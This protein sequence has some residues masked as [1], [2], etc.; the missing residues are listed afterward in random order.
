MTIMDRL[1][2]WGKKTRVIAEIIGR[3]DGF[4]F[5]RPVLYTSTYDRKRADYEFWDKLRSG[6]ADGYE[7]GGIYCQPVYD[8]KSSYVI[9]DAPEYLIDDPDVS[10]SM[11]EHTNREIMA[12]VNRYHARFIQMVS[13]LYALGDQFVV[14]NPNGELA[15]PTPES[16]V[17]IKF[18]PY[19]SMR[20][21]YA[22]MRISTTLG[23]IETW[24]YTPETI[25][26]VHGPGTPDTVFDNLVGEVPV[27]PWAHN[28]R[29]NE[30][31][32]RPDME[33][34]LPWLMEHHDVLD[35]TLDGVKLMGNPI[36]TFT[37]VDDLGK[38]TDANKTS[39][40]QT[41]YDDDSVA[42]TR[43]LL[44]F[45]RQGAILAGKGG[46]FKFVHPAIGFTEDSIRIIDK[47]FDV[48]LKHVRVP[49]VVWGGARTGDRAAAEVQ[50]P[51]FVRYIGSLR[52]SLDGSDTHGFKALLRIWLKTM[53]LTD[54]KIAVARLRSQWKSVALEDS[55]I[56]L[57]KVIYSKGENL[58]R[59]ETALRALGIQ[60]VSDPVEEVRAAKEEAEEYRDDYE[61]MLNAAARQQMDERK[62]VPEPEAPITRDTAQQNPA[63]GKRVGEAA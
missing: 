30:L 7:L 32:G 50:M 34:A 62:N 2:T 16:I 51:P 5:I 33:A 6:A 15:F 55:Q 35:K 45:D 49:E 37:G 25:T 12:M 27:I 58:I 53:R 44:A 18:D 29:S 3:R 57:Q 28:R 46:D 20:V 13:D 22:E 4:E 17:D 26:V 38:T 41:Y 24:K 43:E 61:T 60:A 52:T 48:L 1:R 19:D 63:G 54:R 59:R 36:P 9:G 14:V 8:I 39:Y 10:D 11:R 31:F 42:V 40:D 23:K 56:D 47:I 21:V